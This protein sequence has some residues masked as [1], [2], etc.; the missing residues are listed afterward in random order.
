MP[1]DDLVRIPIEDAIDLHSFAP[2]DILSVVDEY[3]TAARDAGHGDV[4]LIHGRGKGVQRA[5][6][7]RLLRSHP[8]V[9]RFWDAP[10]SHLGATVVRLRRG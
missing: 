1:D 9:E 5:D 2:S 3:L 8:L 7:Q 6:I 4:R 10:E